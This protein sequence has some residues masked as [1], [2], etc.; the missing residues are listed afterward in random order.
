MRSPRVT[1]GTGYGQ[2]PACKVFKDCGT[3]RVCG[4]ASRRK[5]KQRVTVVTREPAIATSDY[6]I[7]DKNHENLDCDGCISVTLPCKKPF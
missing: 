3:A 7:A 6:A 1:A 4:P 2:R 5:Q